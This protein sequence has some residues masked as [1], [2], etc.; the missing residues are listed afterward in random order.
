MKKIKLASLVLGISA[1]STLMVSCGSGDGS[2]ASTATTNTVNTNITTSSNK[3]LIPIG[4]EPYQNPLQQGGSTS[5]IS[6]YLYPDI[7]YISQSVS[8]IY[9]NLNKILVYIDGQP[10]WLVFDTG[11][12]GILVN[13]SAVNLPQNAYISQTFYGMFGGGTTFSGTDAYATVCLNPSNTNSCVYMP[14]AVDTGGNS[15]TLSGTNNVQGDFGAEC[16]NQWDGFVS[17]GDFSSTGTSASVFGYNYAYYLYKEN[18]QLYNSFSLMYY[19]LN[20]GWWGYVPYNSPEGVITFGNFSGSPNDYIPYPNRTA[21]I[22]FPSYNSTSSITTSGIFDTGT[23]VVLLTTNILQNEIPNFSQT[24]DEGECGY[25]QVNG[26]LSISYA[27]ANSSYS[28]FYTTE[29]PSNMCYIGEPG[30]FTYIEDITQDIGMNAAVF[31]LQIIGNAEML[32][33]SYIFTLNNQGFSQGIY[34][35]Q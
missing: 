22:V 13:Q 15:F 14:I 29:P 17:A 35:T 28:T 25:N 26:G 18:P 3:A 16:G 6:A 10:V 27:F 8:I 7:G 2:T 21:N 19:P 12:C 5:T 32:R 4:W 24:L 34:V 9:I 11:A 20:N 33:H 23:S 30:A 1:A 31:G